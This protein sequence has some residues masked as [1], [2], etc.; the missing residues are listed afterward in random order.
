[1]DIEFLDDGRFILFLSNFM[2][3]DDPVFYLQTLR[4]FF[5]TI[6]S[7][8]KPIKDD[9]EAVR[10]LEM[11]ASL[12][13]N[14][15]RSH[16]TA[17]TKHKNSL[18][19]HKKRTD[20]MFAEFSSYLLEAEAQVQTILRVALGTDEAATE[21]LTETETYLRPSV[22]LKERLSEILDD[23]TRDFVK[24]FLANYDVKEG[25]QVELK[26][27]IERAKK[28]HFSEKWV[29]AAR[30]DVFQDSAWAK[31]SRFI[32]GVSAKIE[33]AVVEL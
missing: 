29:R 8:S 3:H 11:K 7:M 12:V 6:E 4:P 28:N 22:F 16:S 13:T 9:A 31:G 15:L 18:V 1:V 24:W 2:R 17:V 30:D 27:M 20:A 26:D 32:Q 19:G 25:T 5:D 10:A 21:V 23:K 14:L 33:A